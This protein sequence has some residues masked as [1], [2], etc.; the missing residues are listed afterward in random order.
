MKRKLLTAAAVLLVLIAVFVA[1]N[2]NPRLV[3]QKKAY[4]EGT[5]TI[6]AV[7]KGVT[8]SGYFTGYPFTLEKLENGEWTKIAEKGE[9]M[10]EMPAFTLFHG[11]KFDYHIGIYTDNITEGHY[12][13]V[14]EMLHNKTK[15]VTAMYCEFDVK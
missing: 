7:W 12:R 10:F 4:P 13:I 6:T 14:T 3:P 8:L 15:E 9:V 11:K 2:M 5:Q 1:T